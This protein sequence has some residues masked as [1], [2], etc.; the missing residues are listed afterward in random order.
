MND[1]ND[2]NGWQERAITEEPAW[3]RSAGSS[4]SAR[5]DSWVLVAKVT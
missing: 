5:Q 3:T 2:M 1:M 4:A